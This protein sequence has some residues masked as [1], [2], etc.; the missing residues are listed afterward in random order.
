MHFSRAICTLS[1]R[2]WRK[3]GCKLNYEQWLIFFKN[4]HICEIG[5]P[6]YEMLNILIR[7]SKHKD[8]KA[9]LARFYWSLIFWFHL[10]AHLSLLLLSKGVVKIEITV[11]LNFSS[12]KLRSI[13]SM[14][15]SYLDPFDLKTPSMYSY[16]SNLNNKIIFDHFF[17][18]LSK[19]V[20]S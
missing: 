13:G 6:E 15:V 5:P 14:P 11:N 20:S 3:M 4:G 19:K 7:P 8:V 12:E 17:N 18:N 10:S 9:N 2:K 1:L 16:Q